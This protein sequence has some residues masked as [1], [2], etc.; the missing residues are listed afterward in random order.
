MKKLV[1]LSTLIVSLFISSASAEPSAYDVRLR[2]DLNLPATWFA[3]RTSS[4]CG[5][6]AVPC[7]TSLAAGKAHVSDAEQAICGSRSGCISMAC[8][9]SSPDVSV[10]A[11]DQD[12]C[13]KYFANSAKTSAVADPGSGTGGISVTSVTETTT[14]QPP[15]MSVTEINGMQV[16]TTIQSVI[17]S[18]ARED[19]FIFAVRSSN[20]KA[21]LDSIRRG[22]D[23][24]MT[25]GDGHTP[26]MFSVM[27]GFTKPVIL[28][29]LL[30]H[31]AHVN[32][33]AKDGMT[34]LMFGA[35]VGSG[36]VPRPYID[37]LLDAGADL[38]LQNRVGYTALMY[39]IFRPDIVRDLL[40]K[41]ANPN[42]RTAKGDTA[43]QQAVRYHLS[44]SAQALQER[45]ADTIQSYQ[46]ASPATD[47]P[48]LGKRP[49]GY[50]FEEGTPEDATPEQINR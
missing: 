42:L 47:S 7:G 34:A 44:A 41:G 50:D 25:D 37:R 27:Y 45:G 40:D 33:Q 26:L 14:Y 15:G 39:A 3:C 1:C 38:D 16:K 49:K 30:V 5:L 8:L 4:D 46:D 31:G 23:I 17:A 20:E 6:A 22:A 32:A 21:V 10:P 12:Q 2:K 35:G 43:W 36:G 11:C 28:E 9:K 48:M 29:A 24:N 13:V 19:P 18:P